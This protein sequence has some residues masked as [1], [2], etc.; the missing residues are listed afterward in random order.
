MPLHLNESELAKL[1]YEVSLGGFVGARAE[2]ILAKYS[3]SQERDDHGRFAG[4]GNDTQSMDNTKHDQIM[5]AHMNILDKV[6]RASG[7]DPT[8]GAHMSM[9][10]SHM[11]RARSAVERAQ[12]AESV[13]DY[14]GASDAYRQAADHYMSA[15]SEY[16]DAAMRMPQT[17]AGDAIGYSIMDHLQGPTD[18]LATRADEESKIFADAV[19]QLDLLHKYVDQGG[20]V[21]MIAKEILIKYSEDEA[22]GEHGRWISS[23]ASGSSPARQAVN[24]LVEAHPDSAAAQSAKGAAFSADLYEREPGNSQAASMYRQAASLI[25]G[26]AMR[27]GGSDGPF[28]RALTALQGAVA[29]YSGGSSTTSGGG[30]GGRAFI[31]NQGARDLVSSARS[32]GVRMPH[33]GGL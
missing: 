23:G 24:D 29:H 3:P 16:S 12:A 21:G 9:A 6:E 25:Q 26:E 2:E 27:E 8:S 20:F 11:D 14:K 1:R 19:K 33:L 15:S 10:Q 22:R 32:M 4:S 17:S 5:S 31:A 30:G 13:N 28:M 7:G 18:E